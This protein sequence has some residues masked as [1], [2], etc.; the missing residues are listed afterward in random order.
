M[1]LLY[2]ILYIVV[3]MHTETYTCLYAQLLEQ[4]FS[5]F[6]YSHYVTPYLSHINEITN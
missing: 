4:M 1:Y 3:F 6:I 5:F 2:F